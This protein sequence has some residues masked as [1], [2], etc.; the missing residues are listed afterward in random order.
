MPALPLIQ[1]RGTAVTSATQAFS[2]FQ[3][4][5]IVNQ[6]TSNNATLTLTRGTTVRIKPGQSYELPP[7]AGRIYGS[8]SLDASSTDCDVTEIL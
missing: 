2:G 5:S 4:L 6:G 1:T 8:V 3:G 7:V